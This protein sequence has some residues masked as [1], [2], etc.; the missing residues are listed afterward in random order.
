MDS[1]EQAVQ[2]NL[3]RRVDELDLTSHTCRRLDRACH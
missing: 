1:G 2:A 3:Q